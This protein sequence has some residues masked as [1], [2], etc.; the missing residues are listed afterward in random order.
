MTRRYA[1]SGVDWLGEIPAEWTTK[2]LWSMF[3]RIKDV[4]HPDEQMLSVFRD[5]GVVPKD[6]RANL[7]KTAE[8]RNIYQL[9]HPG[10]LVT[11]RMKAWQGSVGISEL[12]GIVSG[13][14]I[15]FAPRHDE[16][17]R[18]LNWLFRSPTYATG[19]RLQSRGVRIGQAEIDNDLY[20]A[21]PVLLPPREEQRAIAD[22]LDRETAQ[23]DTLIAEQQRLVEM[24]HER[25]D[26]GWAK[27]YQSLAA[28][29][30][31]LPIRRVIES[32]VDGPFGSSLTSAHYA[33]AGARVIRLG[34]IG[35]NEFKDDDTAYI[36]LEYAAR[37]AVH[38]VRA[39]DVVVAGLGD[40][41][42]PLGR[43]AVVPDI[44]PAIVKAD[45][46]R[47]R[48][49]PSVDPFYLAWALS[50][51]PTRSQIALLSRGATR[52][53]LNTGV[54][55]E[56]RIP[57]PSVTQQRETVR[58]SGRDAERIDALIAET[59]RFIELSRERRSA[60]ITAAVTG[61]I[62]VQEDAA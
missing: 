26:A 21:M 4:G 61:Q 38:A 59:E 54:V 56:A 47:V 34:N 46:Y 22:Y 25:R 41:R 14:Y 52:A 44:G 36:P 9:V 57:V 12:R 42:M 43:A 2:P 32:I 58:R 24:L 13:H 16:H 18:Y 20:R 19:Y 31:T 15:C 6:S 45:C 35:I 27:T 49:L 5:Y 53:R 62:D 29:A 60:L 17:P 37:L 40:D 51:P 23:I 7:N 48:P 50:A 10:W 28:D 3:E 11:N 8:N 55:R 1:D 33:D 39:G 30:A